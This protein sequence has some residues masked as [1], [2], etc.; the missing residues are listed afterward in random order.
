MKH[1]IHTT[2]ILVFA[3]A[4]ALSACAP[5]AAE[6]AGPTPTQP[7]VTPSAVPSP[8]QV[9]ATSTAVPRPTQP[10]A[11]PTAIPSPTQLPD[12]WKTYGSDTYGYKVSYPA[13][14]T[15]QVNTSANAGSS[16]L[17]EYVTFASGPNGR[18]PNIT[19]YA[20]TGIAP[21]TGYE[22]CKPN[23]VFRGLE[24]CRMM[25]PAGQTPANEQIVFH[26]GD[27]YF[28]IILQYQDPADLGTF[29]LFLTS[30]QFTRA[31]VTG[32]TMP[33]LKTYGSKT[34]G[35]SVDYPAD[36]KVEINTTASV[37]KGKDPEYVTFTPLPN[38]GLVNITI[39]ALK[40]AAPFTGYQDCQ[41]NYVFRG[42]KACRISVPAG[43]IP[44][45][46]L[47]IFQ[48]GDDHFEIAMQRLAACAMASW[49]QFL[50]S[51]Q[52]N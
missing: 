15:V 36:W 44:A 24:T 41:Q 3:A 29:D 25:V 38:G 19:L 52:F 33:A 28:E 17:P 13:D 4:L 5:L 35:Y 31:I 22:N 8:T 12:P 27:A 20:L 47:L 32:P 39:Y 1:N 26:N 21:M 45:T 14:W 16:K 10:P 9:E 40:G 6:G 50:A 43:Q 48:K 2:L 18:L 37:G 7:V 23:L 46:E 11:T 51:F 49:D 42:L 34:Y 30:F